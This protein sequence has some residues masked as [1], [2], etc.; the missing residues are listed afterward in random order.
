MHSEKYQEIAE[1]WYSKELLMRIFIIPVHDGADYCAEILD[2]VGLV[3]H[4][5]A[6]VY[7]LGAKLMNP[8]LAARSVVVIVIII[9]G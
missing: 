2:L 3:D 8:F 1:L 5:F 6:R 9:R 4:V 7:T